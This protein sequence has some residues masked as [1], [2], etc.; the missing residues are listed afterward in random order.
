M[1]PYFPVAYSIMRMKMV[2]RRILSVS[3]GGFPRP[4][5]S[6]SLTSRTFAPRW[7][8]LLHLGAF[9]F[10]QP[11]YPSIAVT[12]Y[13]IPYLRH[14]LFRVLHPVSTS[15]KDDDL[16]VSSDCPRCP[17][18][19]TLN[20]CQL[21]KLSPFCLNLHEVLSITLILAKMKFLSRKRILMHSAMPNSRQK[22]V[23]K[24]GTHE[25]CSP[26]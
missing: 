21:L 1:F 20:S 4:N 8:S 14:P 17:S 11:P 24:S 26:P 16:G 13:S 9:L 2:A 25:A 10:S 22:K 6:P 23:C 18:W 15:F 3:T 5:E 19:S 7:L 12:T